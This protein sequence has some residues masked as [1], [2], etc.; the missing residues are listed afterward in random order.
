MAIMTLKELKENF[1][2][3]ETPPTAEDFKKYHYHSAVP[4]SIDNKS[5]FVILKNELE[6][7]KYEYL[8]S[9]NDYKVKE[10][11]FGVIIDKGYAYMATKG[12]PTNL[13]LVLPNKWTL[14]DRNTKRDL[15][16]VITDVDQANDQLLHD[17]YTKTRDKK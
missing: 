15:E 1:L 2:V 14:E 7:R 12:I 17:L 10:G 11:I 5:Y 16:V 8:E 3:Q 6:R 9:P 4:I 13:Q